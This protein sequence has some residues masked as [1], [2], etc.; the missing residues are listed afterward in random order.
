[1]N[2]GKNTK[3][4]CTCKQDKPY[5]DFHKN[6]TTVDG[7]ARYCRA[8][9]SKSSAKYREKP[10]VRIK[11]K[12]RSEEYRANN[13][14]KCLER[15]RRLLACPE[16]KAKKKE[17]RHNRYANNES[18]REAYR[19]RRHNYM[20]RRKEARQN[21]F[22]LKQEYVND[23]LVSQENK[24][25]YCDALLDAYHIDHIEPLSKGGEHALYN[26]VLSCPTCNLRKSNKDPEEFI[27][28][29]IT[30]MVAC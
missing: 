7:L 10:E 19:I 24:C 3:R 16:Y 18:V 20:A 11:M 12:K 14:E 28:Q 29:V 1:M 21:Q 8:C 4:C 26:L 22:R 5:S 25:F 17:Y 30:E 23:M 2:M 15:D 9:K 6:K 27:N 13:I